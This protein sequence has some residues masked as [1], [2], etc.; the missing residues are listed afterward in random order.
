MIETD[1]HLTGGGYTADVSS[2]RG[3]TCFRLLHTPTGADIL[4][5]PKDEAHLSENVYLFGNPLLF[6]PNRIVGGEF[7][8]EGKEYKLPLNEPAT[9]CHVHGALYAKPFCIEEQTKS[10]VRLSYRAQAGE[11][12][13]FPHAFTFVREYTLDETGLCERDSITNESDC[14]MPFLLAYHTTFRLAPFP[15]SALDDARIRLRVGREEMR[16]EKFIPTGEFRDPAARE[17]ALSNGTYAPHGKHL[18]AFYEC[19]DTMT[20]TDT[21]SKRS[22]LYEGDGQFSYRMLFAS[23]DGGFFVCEPQTAAI[24]CFHLPLSPLAYGLAVIA[25]RETKVYNTRIYVK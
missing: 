16:T 14:R 7:T 5:T 21:K 9:G 12:I 24:D 3:G 17:E 22:V 23:A 20:L 19:S 25:P 2:A 11:Y 10:Y 6:P 13:N 8:F 1:I 4:R 15:D 18:S